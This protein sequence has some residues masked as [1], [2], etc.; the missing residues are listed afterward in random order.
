DNDDV[1]SLAAPAAD[2]E[3]A[4]PAPQ[5]QHLDAPALAPAPFLSR[6]LQDAAPAP[7]PAPAPAAPAAPVYAE[8][9]PTY[10]ER[11]AP[12][13]EPAIDMSAMT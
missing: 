6:R 9:A 10:A 7:A 13:P 11:R 12:A 1:A 3:L 5:L 8:P 2:S 4:Q